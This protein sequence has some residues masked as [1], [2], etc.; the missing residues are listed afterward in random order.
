MATAGS[1]QQRLKSEIELLAERRSIEYEIRQIIKERGQISEKYNS[2]DEAFTKRLVV[3]QEKL[4]GIYTARRRHL[5]DIA[6]LTKKLAHESD[7]TVR[8]NLKGILS[9]KEARLAEL[10]AVERMVNLEKSWGELEANAAIK[11]KEEDERRFERGMAY[12]GKLGDIFKMQQNHYMNLKNSTVLQG[13]QLL[14]AAS[15]LAVF[16]T[17]FELFKTMDES[18]AKFR[19]SMGMMR[20][21]AERVSKSIKE[22]ATQFAHIGV[23]MDIAAT[24]VAAL[25]NEFGGTMKIS[26]DLV[27]NVSILKAQL[28]V[29]EEVSAGFLR[30][31]GALSRSTAQSQV[32]MT[33]LAN[34][35]TAAAGIPLNLVMQDVAKMSAN[36]L[37][38]VSKMPLAI[39]KS[40]VSARQMGTTINKM[41]DAS[42]NLLNFTESVQAEMEASVLIGE[43]INV[44]QARQLAYQGKIVESTKA[45]VREAKRINFE[46]LDYFQMQAFA[47]ASGRSADEILRMIQAQRQLQEAR[48]MDGLKDE[49]ALYDRLQTSRES[50]LKNMDLQ[51]KL[52]VQQMAN[53]ARLDQ[54][55]QQWNQLWME[56]MRVMYPVLNIALQL[57]TVLVRIGPQLVILSTGLNK[58]FG[59]S[60]M[61]AKAW[62]GG[63]VSIARI[64]LGVAK[65]GDR[66]IAVMAMVL[67]PIKSI[68]TLLSKIPFIMNA[69]KFAAPFTKAIPVIGWI[70]TAFQFIY[71]M[72]K[73]Y[74]EFTKAGDNPILAGLKAI[75]YALYDTLLAPFVKVWDWIKRIFVG[76]SPSKLGLGIVRGIVEVQAMIFDALTYPWRHFLAW[77]A[78]KIPG[79]GGIA[80]KLRGGLR[81]GLQDVGVL[82]KKA[83]TP[84]VTPLEVN[85]AATPTPTT[86]VTPIPTP[87]EQ[88]RREQ[89]SLSLANI[90]A[91]INQLN[92]NLQ[93]GKIGVYIDGQLMSATLSRQTQFKGGYGVNVA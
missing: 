74:Q 58:I 73:R 36:A 8:D 39:V 33:Y 83:A 52:M 81:G 20:S 90:L 66:F 49:V 84:E 78:D 16:Q 71:N 82:E 88:K 26:Q 13:K 38:M 65:F 69:L 51:R 64:T 76:E 63:A 42:A 14:L 24:S 61:L 54:L 2:I 1:T 67:K 79:M 56:T 6:V 21:D 57:A 19:I 15:L 89:D 48:G 40:A 75:G 5:D 32:H 18:L 55:Q 86:T 28:G 17:Q 93:A 35:M 4:R 11:R 41:A 27:E 45:I 77:V 25:A 29:S 22:V 85:T 91:A 46:R 50:D 87:E 62:S 68:W 53:Q 47:T 30:N 12:V 10:D 31:M 7:V 44:Q 3:S 59:V 60:E 72:F 70:I 34:E 37:A 9:Q 80:K 23:S 43:A 92:A